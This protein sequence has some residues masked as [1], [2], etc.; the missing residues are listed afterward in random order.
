M[1]M[2][3]LKTKLALPQLFCIVLSVA[4]MANWSDLVGFT[5]TVTHVIIGDKAGKLIFDL[6]SAKQIFTKKVESPG[7]QVKH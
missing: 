1:S 4:Q 6:S 3:K 7:F 5:L 2:S